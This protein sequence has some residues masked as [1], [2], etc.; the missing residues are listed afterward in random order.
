MKKLLLGTNRYTQVYIIDKPGQGGA[1][2]EYII[3]S[4]KDL[5]KILSKISFQNGPI[6]E[7]GVNGI[8]QED[9][10]NIVIHRLQGF[11]SGQYACEDNAL[12]LKCIEDAVKYLDRRTQ[13][14]LDRGVEGTYIV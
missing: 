5:G 14:R 3:E 1:N 12:A 10:L 4:S 8:A 2:H 9:L 6:K 11:Q 13:A 7:A